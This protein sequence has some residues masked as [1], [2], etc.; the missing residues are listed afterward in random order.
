MPKKKTK[1]IEGDGVYLGLDLSMSSSGY[2]IM[3]VKDGGYQLIE[4]SRIKTKPSERH[5]LRL[6]AI[7]KRLKD[8]ET[9]YGP[10]VTIV[11]E[12]GFSR[13]AAATQAIFKTVGI[14]DFMFRDYDIE[15][16]TPPSVKKAMSGNGKASKQQ[17]EAEVRRHLNLPDEYEF[18]SDDV[19]DAVAVLL[20]YLFR[21]GIVNGRG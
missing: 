20:S 13:F 1:K 5:G 3:E 17:I 11:R 15:E 7:A 12:R 8:I 18:E 6:Y 19:S 16:I 10:F 4:A 21:E 9:K 14:S 2:A